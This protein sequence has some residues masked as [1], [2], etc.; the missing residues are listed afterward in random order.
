MATEI[1]KIESG[2]V[3]VAK[4][5]K[6]GFEDAGEDAL[7]LAGFLQNNATEIATLAALAGKKGSTV[8]TVAMNLLNQVVSAVKAG[9]AAAGANGLNVSFDAAVIADVKAVITDLES[10]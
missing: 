8:S 7:K 4:K 1:Q 5:V 10:L 2:I 3:D 9:G 6:A